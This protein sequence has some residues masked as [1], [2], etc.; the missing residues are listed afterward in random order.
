MS[1]S[2]IVILNTK[3]PLRAYLMTGRDFIPHVFTNTEEAIKEAKKVR[4]H[5]KVIAL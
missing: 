2:Y 1:V 3:D 5:F 4:K